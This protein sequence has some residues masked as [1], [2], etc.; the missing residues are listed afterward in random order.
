M[1]TL[2]FYGSPLK[3]SHTMALVKK[4]Q[5]GL[6]G[7]V[8]LIDCYRADVKPCV[9]CK[10]C[11]KNIGCSIKDD[12]QEIY[13]DIEEADLIIIATPMHFGITSAPMFTLFSR[14]QSYWSS[15][16]IRSK[17]KDLDA[18]KY[19]IL[20]VTTGGD[21]VNMRLVLEGVTDIAFDHMDVVDVIGSVYAKSTDNEPA[22][23]NHRAL[24]KVEYL[25]NQA[26]ELLG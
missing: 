2:I 19:G 20:L 6:N 7:E 24:E 26:N 23:D 3:D 13:K 12:M 11:F 10:Y 4:A 1:K 15:R 21:W 5:E 14:L 8:K 25:V 17:D 16:N 22:K 9:D 18:K